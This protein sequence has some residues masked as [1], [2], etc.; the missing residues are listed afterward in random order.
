MASSSNVSLP[1][2]SIFGGEE[3]DF[4]S[5]RMKTY[6]RAYDLWDTVVNGYTP[7]VEGNEVEDLTVQQIKKQKEDSTKNFKALSFLHSAVEPSL[8]PRI[9]GASIAKEAWETF[10]EKFQGS[11]RVRAIR[12]LN[13][14]RDFHNL[15]MKDSEAVKEYVSKLMKVVN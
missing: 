10:Q 8:F 12:L 5:A 15:K 4:W 3:N 2:P 6:L 9:V 13:L 1:S 11:E 14:R 7:P